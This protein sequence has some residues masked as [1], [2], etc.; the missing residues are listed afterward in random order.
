MLYR[1]ITAT[2]KE[3]LTSIPLEIKSGKNYT[4]HSALST[5]V[6]NKDYPVQK[7]FVLSNERTIHT[8]NNITYL[9]ICYIM[10]F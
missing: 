2:I 8:A 6:K 1:K 7:A 9:P 3:H 5:F 10:F 4:V